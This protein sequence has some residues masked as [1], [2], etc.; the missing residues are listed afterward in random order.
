MK[1]DSIAGIP[2]TLVQEIVGHKNLAMTKYYNKF[3]QRAINS[4]NF[5]ET[6]VSFDKRTRIKSLLDVVDDN[7]LNQIIKILEE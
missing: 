3:R 6:G 7:K 4:L 2:D 1:N 5:V